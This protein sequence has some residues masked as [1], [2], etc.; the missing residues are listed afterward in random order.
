MTND[1]NDPL[2]PEIMIKS[3]ALRILG[4]LEDNKSKSKSKAKRTVFFYSHNG[5][6]FDIKVML[7]YLYKLHNAQGT[8]PEQISDST[9]DIFQ[10][11]VVHNKVVMVFR[12]SIK[13]ILGS[14]DGIAK[15]M[16]K[17]TSKML[18]SHDGVKSLVLS[19]TLNTP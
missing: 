15:S 5:G 11:S 7:K 2:S 9:H 18:I 6:K 3:M 10:V 16:L 8:L 12:D 1:I 19:G 13:I 14:V 17:D 4:Y